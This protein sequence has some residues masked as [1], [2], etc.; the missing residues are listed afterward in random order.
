MTG[1]PGLSGL[2][3]DPLLAEVFGGRRDGLLLLDY[4]GTLAPFRVEREKAAPYPGVVD[5]LRRL[6]SRGGGRFVVIS[7]R[8]AGEVEAFL[9]PATP[10]E[11]WGCHGAQR[12]RPG[13][14]PWTT[15][16]KPQWA[17]A[18][19]RAAD[20]AAAY[21][22][23]G[24]LERKGVSL[25]LHWRSMEASQRERLRRH[26]E[27][28]W[29]RLAREAGLA[30][31]PFDGGLEL[32]PPDW[33]KGGAVRTLRRENPDAILVYL[34]DDRTDEDAFQ[35]LDASG[36]GVLVR[37]APRPT[38]ARYRITPPDELLRFLGLWAQGVTAQGAGPGR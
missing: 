36:L 5:I 25:A 26:I 33:D 30:A 35:A 37:A 32:R 7:G 14:E 16:L 2:A 10:A 18:L 1:P 17:T 6:P 12:L 4:D 13:G 21:V 19:E 15:A 8:M 34:G 24:A 38:A 22:A 20:M 31:H 9:H 28:L 11:I 3:T 23:P 27:P 29:S